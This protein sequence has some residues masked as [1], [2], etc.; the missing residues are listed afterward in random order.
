[1]M[2]SP[3][4]TSLSVKR[5]VHYRVT[6]VQ[7]RLAIGQIVKKLRLKQT[8]GVQQN[9][10]KLNEPPPSPHPASLRINENEPLS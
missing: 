9:K 5:C 7:K 4:L 3:M 1:M 2:T 8:E 6:V 10:R